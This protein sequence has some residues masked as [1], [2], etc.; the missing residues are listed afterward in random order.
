MEIIKRPD[1]EHYNRALEKYI[2]SKRHYEEELKKAGCVPFEQG[3]DMAEEAEK[4]L[5]KDY[6]P[7]DEVVKFLYQVKGSV[8]KDGKVQL[9]GRQIAYME[10]IGVNFKRPKDRGTKEGWE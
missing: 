10:K 4:K 9:S 3:K 6:K 5:H 7:T 8:S 2:R 1:Y